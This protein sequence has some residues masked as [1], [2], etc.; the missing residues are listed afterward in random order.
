MCA[1]NVVCVMKTDI[2]QSMLHRFSRTH[3]RS[4]M[5]WFDPRSRTAVRYGIYE[6][7]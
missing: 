1:T 6:F 4:D 3:I 7:S 5:V 2:D